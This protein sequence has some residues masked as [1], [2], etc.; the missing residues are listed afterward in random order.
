MLDA[1]RVLPDDK[2]T[3]ILDRADDAFSF[4]FERRLAPAVQPRFVR[5]DFDENPIAHVRV[6]D[7]S[8]DIC[9]FHFDATYR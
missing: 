3:H 7:D 2:A 6:D 1:S 9:D 4:P 5:L 8:G